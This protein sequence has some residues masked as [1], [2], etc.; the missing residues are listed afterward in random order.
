[1]PSEHSE[2]PN[3]DNQPTLL[4]TALL[5]ALCIPRS[6]VATGTRFCVGSGGRCGGDT[7]TRIIAA[8]V[9]SAFEQGRV[10]H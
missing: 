6:T 4:P 1:M 7:P 2:D 8:A 5:S 10:W 3:R 9:L